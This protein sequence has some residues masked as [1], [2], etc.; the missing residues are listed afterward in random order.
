M[1]SIIICVLFTAAIKTSAQINIICPKLIDSSLNYFYIGVDNPIKVIGNKITDNYTLSITGG[2]AVITKMSANNY[3][4][5]TTTVTDDC[6]IVIIGKAGKVI[7]RK[8]FKIRNIGD[9]V[10]GL[11]SLR[12]TT[13]NKNKILL[14][15]FLST[16]IPNCYFK[17]PFQ[18]VSFTA[19]FSNDSD[20]IITTIANGNH[21]SQEQLSLVKEADPGTW[22]TFE[23]IKVYGPDSR[24]RKVPSFWIKIE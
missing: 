4:V 23:D 16:G 7:F 10:T 6:R 17:L 12:D 20:S 24:T 8:D 13:L 5:K 19:T 3:I 14:N 18:V 22:I 11:A 1:R 15:P 2:G 21:L 9:Q